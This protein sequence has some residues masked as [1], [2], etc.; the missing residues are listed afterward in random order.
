MLLKMGRML[1]ILLTITAG[2]GQKQHVKFSD[3]LSVKTYTFL[4]GQIDNAPDARLGA[5]YNKA[6]LKKAREEGDHGQL[7]QGYKN[8]LHFQETYSARLQY[9]DSMLLESRYLGAKFEASALLTKGAVHY[10]DKIYKAALDCYLTAQG[11]LS[12]EPEGIL[13][14]K[15][16]YCIAQ[17]KYYLGYYPQAIKLLTPC[18]EK[19][20]EQET[21]GYI[22]SMHLLGLC[23]NR[24]GDYKLCSAVNKAGIAAASGLEESDMLPYFL[25]SEGI[26]QYFL[27]Y[28]PQ[29]LKRLK[30]TLPFLNDRGDY[31]NTAVAWCYIGRAN[32]KV[33]RPEEALLAY[34]KVY[35]IFNRHN[36]IRP[37]LVHA[38]YALVEQSKAAGDM[39]AELRYTTALLSADSL[40]HADFRYLSD[41]MHLEY[42]TATLQKEKDALKNALLRNDEINIWWFTLL[43]M[44]LAVGI[45]II[46]KRRNGRNIAPPDLNKNTPP[47]PAKSPAANLREDLAL[48]LLE[49]LEKFERH[50]RYL[51]KD[52][53]LAMMAKHLETNTKYVSMLIHEYRDKKT[54]DYLNDLKIDYLVELLANN[55]KTHNYTHKALAAEI[56]FSTTNSLHKAF[57]SRMG[58]AFTEY[59]EKLQTVNNSK[60]PVV[61]LKPENPTGF[62]P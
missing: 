44:P 33:G 4:Q 43:I 11:L 5:L 26:N 17:V 1:S 49:K 29:A 24:N 30:S 31:A 25:H 54:P 7:F 41:R 16:Q 19:F 38:F 56:G 51:A 2:Y 28:Y 18:L 8:S 22:N 10:N 13:Y 42:D 45:W 59:L 55:K 9:A 47:S 35:D 15:A 61:I 48:V 46:A 27:G 6:L 52:M 36:Y 53:N 37:D 40:M 62:R 12:N 21:R 60:E 58:I 20:K 14:Y 50:K 32:D 3:S 34:K 57:A 39:K 23:Y